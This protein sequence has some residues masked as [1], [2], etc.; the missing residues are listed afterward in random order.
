MSVIIALYS[1]FSFLRDSSIGAWN[2]HFLWLTAKSQAGYC[3]NCSNKRRHMRKKFTFHS[4]C[5]PFV[6]LP[7]WFNWDWCHSSLRTKLYSQFSASRN[8]LQVLLC[9][10]NGKDWCLPSVRGARFAC[11]LPQGRKTTSRKELQFDNSFPFC[12]MLVSIS[13]QQLEMEIRKLVRQKC[14]F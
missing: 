5:L 13:C 11:E 3:F 4:T 1:L 6:D 7:S 2:C 12:C 8:P 14:I 9:F 10:F